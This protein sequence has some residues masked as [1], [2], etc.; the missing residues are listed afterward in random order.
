VAKHRVTGP[1]GAT[2]DVTAPDDASQE[3]IMQ[4]VQDQIAP[5][6]LDAFRAEQ[7]AKD[8][9]PPL[10]S[11]PILGGAEGA[12][13]LGTGMIA[14]PVSGLMGLAGAALPGP[15]G[16]G[17]EW[18]RQ[19]AEDM[20]YRPTSI[21]GQ[22]GLDIVSY[23]FVKLSELANRWGEN[24]QEG[25]MG[26]ALEPAAPAMGTLANVAGNFLPS[27]IA[28]GIARPAPA[29]PRGTMPPPRVAPYVSGGPPAVMRSGR[30]PP[31]IALDEL[32]NPRNLPAVVRSEVQEA[33]DAGYKLTPTQLGK[34]APLRAVE[35]LAGSA[36]LEKLASIENQKVSNQWIKDDLGITAKKARPEDLEAV[37][38]KAGGAYEEVKN[39]AKLIKPDAQFQGDLQ[40][41]RGDFTQAA[42][43]YPEIMS[44]EA[45]EG[46][47]ANLNRAASPAAMV[48]LTKKL[49]KDSA[50][51]LKSFD[52][53]A[54]RELGF[55]QLGAAR[56]LENMIDRALS[57]VGKTG[58][59]QKWRE[60]RQMIAKS[61]SAEA[62]FNETTGD[63]SARTLAAMYA[64]GEPMTGGMEKV[65]RFARSFEGAAR[66]PWK[67]R[68]V[69]EF[70]YGDL[71]LGSV[72]GFGAGL[73]GGG[74]GASVP[75]LGL[76]LARPAARHLLL[77]RPVQKGIPLRDIGRAAGTRTK[78]PLM[79]TPSLGL[80]VPEEE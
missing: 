6:K 5:S 44:N 31:T 38:R 50:T 39:A 65:A 21:Q 13:A 40:T 24:V 19:T 67:M 18:Q 3:A 59:V 30:A 29:V 55:A 11:R 74:L 14:G 22:A 41:L 25:Y 1:D 54:K 64:K 35:G 57:S 20:T 37:R 69:S 17:A 47:I 16:Q 60:A 80:R 26:T 62:A 63:F 23:P 73:A 27:L 48:E 70:S 72:G 46:L 4:M 12:L 53:P 45:V 61:Y 36:K 7:A 52:D 51:N 75:G 68:D 71:L 56:A 33:I 28:K 76:V 66:D 9:P 43:F 8:Q 10:V 77:S 15:A 2:Y 58:L 34:G 42:N 49:R 78:V 32:R 79:L